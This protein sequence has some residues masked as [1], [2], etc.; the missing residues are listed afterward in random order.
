MGPVYFTK[1]E[2]IVPKPLPFGG[3][4]HY[5]VVHRAALVNAQAAASRLFEI[6]N[7][8]ATKLL[9]PIRL[10]MTILQTGAQHNGPSPT[11]D[12]PTIVPKN[13]AKNE[14]TRF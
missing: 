4:G 11:G 2:P 13:L 5:R 6:R 8:S 14:S 3:G 10:R 9:V 7:P 1:A 12:G